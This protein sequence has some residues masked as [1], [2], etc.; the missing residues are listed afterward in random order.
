M[1]FLQ[2]IVVWSC[3]V[4]GTCLL[5]GGFGLLMVGF[6]W[7]NENYGLLAAV[8]SVWASILGVFAYFLVRDQ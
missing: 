5:Y 2:F 4:I 7:L 3:L 6:L 8:G 1:R